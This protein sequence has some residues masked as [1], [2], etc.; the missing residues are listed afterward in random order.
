MVSEM[1]VS[2]YWRF[3]D[4]LQASVFDNNMGF[5]KYRVAFFPTKTHPVIIATPEDGLII[6]VVTYLYHWASRSI[7]V[8]AQRAYAFHAITFNRWKVKFY[9][10][11]TSELFDPFQPLFTGKWPTNLRH[12]DW[13]SYK[14]TVRN[15]ITIVNEFIISLTQEALLTVTNLSNNVTR[16]ISD[17]YI[18]LQA[19]IYLNFGLSS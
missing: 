1:Y 19:A 3:I 17:P 14:V 18:L 2:Y 11:F 4:K 16:F 9:H 10:F 13:I 5:H 7:F 12:S 6:C 8:P 15:A